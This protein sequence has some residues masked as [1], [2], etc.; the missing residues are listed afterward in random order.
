MEHPIID[1]LGDY[2]TTGIKQTSWQ[3]NWIYGDVLNIC[4]QNSRTNSADEVGG[5]YAFGHG[6]YK[7]S[8]PGIGQK[9]L[10]FSF[11]YTQGLWFLD[12]PDMG[13][14]YGTNKIYSNYQCPQLY[15]TEIEELYTTKQCEY[16]DIA[17]TILGIQAADIRK[18]LATTEYSFLHNYWSQSNH[19]CLH[20][21]K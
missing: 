9:P 12:G 14:I 5:R 13:L 16:C 6:L 15:L 3:P 21:W 19:S 1:R 10:F 8:R 17:P 20:S 4:Q 11:P 7:L 2:I 18:Y